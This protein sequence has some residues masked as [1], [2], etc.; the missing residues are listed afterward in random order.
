MSVLDVWFNDQPCGR[1]SQDKQG[2]LEFRYTDFWMN[3]GS[4]PVSVSLPLN[5]QVHSNEIVA[6]FVA[7]Q[8][9]EGGDVRNRLERLLHVDAADDFGLLS[10]IGRECAGALSYWPEDTVPGKQNASYVDL[11]LDD[12]HRWREFAHHQ[13]FQFQGQ[14]IRLSLAG[15]Q[16]KTALYFDQDGK[17]FVPMNGAA[18]SHILKPRIPGVSP[19]TIFIELLTMSLARSVLDENA[20]PATDT[21][22]NCYRI[23]RFD[24]PLTSTGVKRLHQEDFCQAL[25]RFP[26]GKYEGGSPRERL[27]PSC[28]NLLDRLGNLG[29]IQSPALER[30]RLLNQVILNV[31]LHNPDAHLKNYALLYQE[32]GYAQVSPMYDSLCTHDLKFRGDSSGGWRG[33]D[34]PLAHTHELSLQIGDSRQIDQVTIMDWEN[35]AIE[36]GFTSAF[37]RRRVKELSQT[38]L[39][40]SDDVIDAL[41]QTHPL[42]EPAANTIRSALEKQTRTFDPTGI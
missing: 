32:D 19:N 10:A 31:L 11:D 16:S 9:P 4:C 27:L 30:Q 15:N 23:R 38:L 21:W 17:P 33:V 13:P 28:F 29:V 1:L 18:T 34:S 35:M 36:C 7:N 25:G 12:F 5:R 26:A 39:D 42:L 6:P 22:Q 20:V 14:T 8:L 40:A 3:S 41:L 37:V 24:R 2:Q